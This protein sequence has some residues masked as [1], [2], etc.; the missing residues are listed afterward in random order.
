MVVIDTYV[1]YSY[2]GYI[3]MPDTAMAVTEMAVRALRRLQ[4]TQLQLQLCDVL[5]VGYVDDN[6]NANH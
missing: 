3:Y 6:S 4:R 5:H 1:G 2:D